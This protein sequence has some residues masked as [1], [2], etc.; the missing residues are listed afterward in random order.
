MLLFKFFK[1]SF[2]G[3][4]ANNCGGINFEVIF[5]MIQILQVEDSWFQDF[6]KKQKH[7]KN[8][9]DAQLRKKYT[10]QISIALA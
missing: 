7:T 1:C 10:P 2:R 5:P 4:V 3:G 8:N 9:L 6:F